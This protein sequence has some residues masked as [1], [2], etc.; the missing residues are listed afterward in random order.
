[1]GG[2]TCLVLAPR[3][4]TPIKIRALLRPLGYGRP[5]SRRCN[6]PPLRGSLTSEDVD[7]SRK[8]RRVRWLHCEHRHDEVGRSRDKHKYCEDQKQAASHVGI[9][10]TRETDA[11]WKALPGGAERRRTPGSSGSASRAFVHPRPGPVRMI[12]LVFSRI[13]E[14]ENIT[15]RACELGASRPDAPRRLPSLLIGHADVR[16]S[17]FVLKRGTE[18]ADSR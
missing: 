7:Y 18:T 14:A 15:L 12:G 6:R 11:I 3:E 5:R 2:Q 17:G 10:R 16:T 1:M 4:L 9:L 13:Q 8:P